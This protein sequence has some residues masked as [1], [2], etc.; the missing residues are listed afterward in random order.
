[1]STDKLASKIES[2]SAWISENAEP[3]E[4]GLSSVDEKRLSNVLRE[5][6]QKINL[7]LPPGIACPYCGGSGIDANK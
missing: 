1:M 5:F 2:L 7:V 6:H 4:N 3:R